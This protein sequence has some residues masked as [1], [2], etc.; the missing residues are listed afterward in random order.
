MGSGEHSSLVFRNNKRLQK[1]SK[2]GFSLTIMSGA[3]GLMAYV[4]LYIA[5]Y[6]KCAQTCQACYCLCKHELL[7]LT[8]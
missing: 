7:E 2:S 5:S 3:N 8:Y 6:C 4:L 1:L